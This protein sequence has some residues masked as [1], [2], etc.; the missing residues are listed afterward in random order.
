MNKQA[1][2]L[3]M[4]R[5]D[6]LEDGIGHIKGVLDDQDRRIGSLDDTRSNQRG[7]ML[8]GGAAVTFF[9]GVATWI[10]DHMGKN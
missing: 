8:G 1:F 6:S 4:A 5:F 2:D 10:V 9:A 7:I 3:M